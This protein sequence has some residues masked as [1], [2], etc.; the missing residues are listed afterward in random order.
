MTTKEPFEQYSTISKPKYPPT[1]MV[2]PFLKNLLTLQRIFWLIHPFCFLL[3]HCRIFDRPCAS[4]SD[5][6]VEILPGQ[7][8]SMAT[9]N[10][11][12]TNSESHWQVDDKLYRRFFVASSSP[13]MNPF[14]K[15]KIKPISMNPFEKTKIQPLLHHEIL[16]MKAR[17]VICQVCL[18]KSQ[19]VAF[20]ELIELLFL[21]FSIFFP[22]VDCSF[23]F[24]RF[25]W[26]RNTN[27][28]NSTPMNWPFF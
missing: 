4:S 21:C 10:P 18:L 17:T 8:F 6:I 7:I 13:S 22:R 1:I 15:T 28:P 14:E 20:E 11:S 23:L 9:Q 16:L 5:I 12:M 24:S 27:L 25:Q 3:R 19:G 2:G 26:A